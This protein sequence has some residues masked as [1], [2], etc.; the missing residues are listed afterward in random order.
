MQTQ[1]DSELDKFQLHLNNIG[2]DCGALSLGGVDIDNEFRQKAH[3]HTGTMNV[4][5]F[6]IF[7]KNID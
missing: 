4:G 3:G 6:K 1:R 7:S 5:S 2:I